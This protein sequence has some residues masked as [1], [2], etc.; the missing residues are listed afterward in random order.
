MDCQLPDMLRGASY[1]DRLGRRITIT[2]AFRRTED[3]HYEK[4]GMT[5]VVREP[6]QIVYFSHIHDHV[7]FEVE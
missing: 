4:V 2:Q 7:D 1:C 6:P 5:E 3:G